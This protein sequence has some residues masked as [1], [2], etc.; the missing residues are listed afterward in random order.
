MRSALS[1]GFLMVVMSTDS[2]PVRAQGALADYQRSDRWRAIVTASTGDIHE[3]AE[4][5]STASLDDYGDFGFTRRG[6]SGR[7]VGMV[8]P[9]ARAARV[10]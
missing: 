8:F 10:A 1:S 4:S 5:E 9:A 7:G 3:S 6:R 2:L